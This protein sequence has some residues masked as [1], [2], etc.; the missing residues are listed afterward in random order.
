MSRKR[1][2]KSPFDFSASVRTTFCLMRGRFHVEVETQGDVDV[3]EL[4]RDIER[5]HPGAKI[6]E[7]EKRPLICVLDDKHEADKE[8]EKKNQKRARKQK[9]EK[10]PLIRIVE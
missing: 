2:K 3:A 1:R 8:E 5:R 6:E 7:L 4:R 9:K 10:Q